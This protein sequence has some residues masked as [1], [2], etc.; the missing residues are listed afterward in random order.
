MIKTNLYNQEGKVVGEMDLPENIFGLKP[1]KDLMHEAVVAQ[2]ANSRI[3]YAHT[4]TRGEVRGGGKKPFAQKHT[5]QARQGSIR[6]P[7]WRH[8]GITFGPTAD[9]SYGKKI[10]LKKK[11]LA[12]HMALASKLNDKVLYIIDDLRLA[13]AKTKTFAKI[14]KNLGVAKT[15]LIA[16][17][18]TD[19]NVYLASRN[20][21]GIKSILIG[22]LN[23]VDVLRYKN[24]IMPKESIAAIEKTFKI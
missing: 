11:R 6:S 20:I 9:A 15:A 3:K 12:L 19:K 2:E 23:I 5:G 4:K 14:L 1:K 13:D 16:L 18:K 7:I 17:P 10:N 24:L 21:P 22:S 8:G